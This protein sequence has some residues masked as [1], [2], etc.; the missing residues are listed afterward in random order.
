ME[1][2]IQAPSAASA[3]VI[4]VIG[5]LADSPASDMPLAAIRARAPAS[6]MAPQR[7]NGSANSA[8]SKSAVV[9]QKGT[10]GLSG[11]PGNRLARDN[12]NTSE[13]IAGMISRFLLFIDV[14]LPAS[15]VIS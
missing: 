8:V 14:F 9:N 1:R 6:N 4:A 12:M 13:A 11:R 3:S 10:R 7:R 15:I 5:S 2:S